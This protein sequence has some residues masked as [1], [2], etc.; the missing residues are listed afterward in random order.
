ME[1]NHLFSLNKK[2]FIIPAINYIKHNPRLLSQKNIELGQ[3]NMEI[4]PVSMGPTGEQGPIGPTGISGKDGDRFCTRTTAKT[5]IRP[6]QNAFI[7][8]DVEPGL[9][10]ISGNSVIVAEVPNSINSNL[11]TFEGTIQF[12]NKETGHIVI[13]D[14]T[15]IHGDFGKHECYYCVNLDGVDGAQGDEGPIGPTGLQ[16]P[17]GI[18]ET[19]I[20]LNLL[21]NSISIPYQLNPIT[22]YTIKVYNN[23]EIKKIQ[24]QLRNNQM[25]I[26][27][28]ELSDLDYNDTSNAT[29]FT[30]YDKKLIINYNRDIL[31]NYDSPFVLIKVINMND[32]IFVECVPYFKNNFI[33]L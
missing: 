31:L 33:S 26:I 29:I 32:H 22:Y 4:Q 8:I 2:T 24:S 7:S 19:S 25:A 10:Y 12:Y 27:L 6:K 5:C 20:P 23:D 18:S 21:D 15:N 1:R 11:Y 17:S 14:I 30:I 13:K 16:G 28:I 9:A 3:K